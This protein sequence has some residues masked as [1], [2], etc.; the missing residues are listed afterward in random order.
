MTY[1]SLEDAQPLRYAD[2][3]VGVFLSATGASVCRGRMTNGPWCFR[4]WRPGS[5]TW[6]QRF[7]VTDRRAGTLEVYL[8]AKNRPRSV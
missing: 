6:Q 3:P 2:P 7:E 5:T 8:S 4:C 1:E